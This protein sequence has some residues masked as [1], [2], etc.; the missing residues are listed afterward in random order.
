MVTGGISGG[1]LNGYKRDFKGIDGIV[2]EFL[3]NFGRDYEGLR[4]FGK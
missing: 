2:D 4:G 3:R 1:I